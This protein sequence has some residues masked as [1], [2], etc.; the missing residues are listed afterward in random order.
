MCLLQENNME[1]ILMIYNV[2]WGEKVPSLLHD[3]S[4]RGEKFTDERPEEN[5][6]LV[7][8]VCGNFFPASLHFQM[9]GI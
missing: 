2:K 4:S 9:F 1:E 3:L 8:G 7:S 5:V 6:P